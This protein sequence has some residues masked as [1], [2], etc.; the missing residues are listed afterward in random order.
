M[1]SAG[2]QVPS[3]Q[4][5]TAYGDARQLEGKKEILAAL[6]SLYATAPASAKPGL[7]AIR[8]GLTKRGTKYLESAS[9]QSAV[10]EVDALVYQFCP[11]TQVPVTAIDYQFEGMPAT[12]PAGEAKFKFTNN[13]PKEPH[14]LLVVKMTA[15]G[16]A[17]DP[18]ELVALPQK[19]AEKLLD[20]SSV[21]GTFAMP[22]DTSYAFISLSSGEYMYACFVPVKG[23]GKPHAMEGMYGTFTVS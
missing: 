4:F 22:G 11:G 17:M 21:T 19:K 20:F 9:G 1:S 23:K 2:A 16:A 8:N 3:T 18:A 12:L 5:C 10:S 6:E 15:E 7:A 14:E 13:A